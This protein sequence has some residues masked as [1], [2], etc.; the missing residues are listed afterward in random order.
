M[1]DVLLAMCVSDRQGGALRGEQAYM[2]GDSSTGKH[3]LRG[4]VKKNALLQ[5]VESQKN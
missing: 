3:H 4:K 2:E 5:T 1:G